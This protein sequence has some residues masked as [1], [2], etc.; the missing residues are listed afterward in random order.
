MREYLREYI[1]CIIVHDTMIHENDFYS[2]L[3]L[4]YT[5]M[6]HVFFAS[7]IHMYDSCRGK[8][9]ESPLNSIHKSPQYA[10]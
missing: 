3:P 6:T 7:L 9:G 2:F 4:F 1:L 5:C 8:K 10:H